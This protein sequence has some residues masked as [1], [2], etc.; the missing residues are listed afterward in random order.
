M[1]KKLL[2]GILALVCCLSLFVGCGDSGKEET[3]GE[4]YNPALENYEVPDLTGKTVDLYAFSNSDWD[5]ETSWLLPKVE[6]TLGVD[7]N[8]V[9]LDSFSQQIA[10][11]IAEGD[12]P[13]ITFANTY[14]DMWETFGDDGAYINVYNYLDFMPNL[15]RYLEDPAHANDVKRYTAREGVL[16]SIP[17]YSPEASDPY[18]FLY[19]QDIFEANNLTFPTNQE[20]FVSVLRKLKELYPKS[21]P[22]V[23]RQINGNMQTVQAF[24]HLW[25]GTHVLQGNYNTIFT[26]DENGEYYMAQ[27]SNAYKE[28]GL[29]LNELTAE[30]LMHPSCATMDTASWYEAFASNTSF[31]TYDKTDRLPMMN[32]SGQALRAEFQVVA[33]APFNFGSYAKET[34]EVSTSFSAGIGSGSGFWYAI[35]KNENLSVAMAYVDWM[36][37]EEGMIL[38]NWGIEGETFE[39]DE[40]GERKYIQSFLDEYGSLIATGLYQPGLVGERMKGAYKASLD[41]FDAASLELGLQY[42]GKHTAQHMLRYNEEEQLTYDTY[43]LALFNYA[44]SQWQKMYMGQRSFDEWDMILEEMKAKYHYDELVAVHDSALERLL[45]ENPAE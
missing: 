32:Y 39:Y 20:E 18:V 38:T 41:E 29:F 12:V 7:L 4:Y 8:Y 33:A 14:N 27:I 40:N 24:S 6:E 10:T 22:F 44:Q 43:A 5:H 45:Q 42:R 28:M 21:Y 26:L 16:Y 25:G 36:F 31:I 15:K 11:M 19:R 3:L 34:D 9:E 13:D 23:L 1:F 2:G 35:G 17:L 37:S 30:G